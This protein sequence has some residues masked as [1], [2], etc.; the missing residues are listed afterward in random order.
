[1]AVAPCGLLSEAAQSE[2]MEVCEEQFNKMEKLQNEIILSEADSSE[3][4]QVQ[5]QAVTRLCVTEAELKLMMSEEPKVLSDNWEVLLEAGTD[6]LQ[7][8]TFDLQSVVSCYE[9]R[10]DKLRETK[11]LELRWLEEKKELLKAADER[12]ERLK[13]EKEKRSELRLLQ[14]MKERI[15]EVKRYQERVMEVLGEVLDK[16]VALPGEEE[17]KLMKAVNAQRSEDVMSLS[18]ILELLMNRLLNAP[19]DPYVTL[20]ASF[21]PPYVEMLLRYGVT[22]RHP[23]DCRRIRLETFS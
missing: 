1:M 6:E 5:D 18:E 15:T 8:L 17:E 2:L 16:H 14:E 22:T 3:T 20:T 10:R 7:R 4:D 9:A 21:W 19:H 12:V 13:M 11:E 23:E